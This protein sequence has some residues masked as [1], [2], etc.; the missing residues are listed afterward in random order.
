MA[1]SV[2]K[3]IRLTEEVY[4]IINKYRG[5]GFNEKFEN[6]ILEFH[7]TI[8]ERE[9]RKKQLDKQIKDLE[10]NLFEMRSKIS[11]EAET[12]EHLAAACRQAE[13]A[14]NSLNKSVSQ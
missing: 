6:I 2:G 4:D 9:K 14:R 11:Y 12:L 7:R 3:S 10:V 5:D 13:R 8:S 1:K